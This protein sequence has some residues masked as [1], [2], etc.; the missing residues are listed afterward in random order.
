[1]VL[2]YRDLFV[3]ICIG[4][5]IWGFIRIE[6]IYQYPFFMGSLFVSVI[7]PQAFTLVEHPG[8]ASQTALERVLLMSCLCAAACWVGYQGKP[9]LEWLVKLK[10]DVDENKL[11]QA[12]I[13]LMLIGYYF[14]FRLANITIQRAEYNDNW[15][16]PA[17]IYLFFSQVIYIAF[18]IFILEAL[19][20]P[21]IKNI[22]FTLL[23][24]WIPLQAVLYGRRQAT[25]TFIIIIGLAFLLIRRYIPPKW[26][27]IVS[28]FLMTVLIPTLGLLRGRF[29]EYLFSGQWQD[30]L[31]ALTRVADD[32]QQGDILELRN[33]AFFMDTAVKLNLYGLGAGWWDSIIFQ[34][35]PGQIVGFG[36]KQSLQ[37]NLIT[38][39]TLLD[40]YGYSVHIGTT[41]TGVGDSFKEFGYL[42]CLIFAL[43]GYSFKYLWLSA[44]YQK[45]YFSYLLYMGLVSPAMVSLTHGVGRFWQETIFQV[46]VISLVIYYAKTK[47]KH[48]LLSVNSNRYT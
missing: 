33:A 25:L 38:D 31:S 1:M 43:I 13:F 2:L 32:Q 48:N 22:I 27:I 42:G 3:I 37:F 14:N 16:G 17:T 9:N 20:R 18:S 12:G 26:F 40:L 24:G 8:Q 23:A 46:G 6:R 7:L 10:V 34:Y 35:V 30:I 5:L 44:Y 28:L 19:K 15:T 41:I 39:K 21:S 47:P 29:W 4:L 45:S 36:F 11:F